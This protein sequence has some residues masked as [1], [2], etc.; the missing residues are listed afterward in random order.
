MNRSAP[1]NS[2]SFDTGPPAELAG[3]RLTIDLGALV[4]NWRLLR[5]QAGGAACA[6][7]VKADAYGIGLE[8]AVGAL[9][10]AGCETFFVAHVAEGARARRASP[11]AVIYV[12]NGLPP[13]TASTYAD[14]DLRPVLGSREEIPEW[15]AFC[16]ASGSP[17]AAAIHVDTGM[18]RLGV[19]V[20]EALSLATDALLSDFT[21][22]LLMTHFV[23]AEEPENPLNA[24]Q[25]RAFEAVRA[26]LPALPSSAANSSGIFLP[27][28]PHYDVVRPGYA[29]YGGNPTPGRRNPMQGV[30]RL[31][32]CIVQVRTAEDG[33]TAG[34]NGQW[35]ARGRRR[36][37]TV[38]VGYADGYPRA[39]SATDAKHADGLP[40]GEAIVGGHR[41]PFAGRVSMDL[42]TIDVTD[43]PQGAAER[44]TPVVLIGDDLAIDEV[45]RRAGTIGYEI[46][47]GL[48]RRYARAYV[49][50][51]DPGAIAAPSASASTFA[52]PE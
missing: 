48:G 8:P 44:G 37:A 34:Y 7:V 26:A 22:A 19:R 50:A 33:E 46:L 31:E 42:I 24:E 39:A 16:R 32:G 25:I 17:R 10:R 52:G 47:T 6:A 29:L 21:P 30:V 5:Q 41:C 3:A 36:L 12:L 35:T 51:G 13:D 15:A 2:S 28:N 49:D 23:S 45:A 4:A 1:Q 40:T 38:S 27:A 18:N 20:S 14:H 11:E 9:T 43:T